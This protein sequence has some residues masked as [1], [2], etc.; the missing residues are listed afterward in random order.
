MLRRYLDA[1][2]RPGACYELCI[3]HGQFERNGRIGPAQLYASTLAGWYDD[4]DK[5]AVDTRRLEGISAY[6]V[7]NPADTALLAR[8]DNRLIRL[9]GREGRTS[10][11]NIARLRW[12]YVDIDAIRVKGVSSTDAE[13]AHAISRRDS[14]LG[15]FPEL[16]A[17]SL[18]GCSGNGGWILA[19]LPDYPNGEAHR[20][21]VAAVLA[22]LSARYSDNVAAVDVATKNPAR[23]MCL[24]GTMKCKGSN[25]P[26]R[27]WRL[28]TLDTPDQV[29]GRNAAA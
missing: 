14:I 16:R 9:T 28:V 24:P 2:I 26:E 4:P 27:P 25:R 23:L 18:W 17:A 19:R 3:L 5:L 22:E 21:H 11:E 10:D 20:K 1:V 7:P 8:S 6:I 12:L 13:L 15:D 29:E